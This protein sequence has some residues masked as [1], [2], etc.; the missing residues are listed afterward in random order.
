MICTD[1][2]SVNEV[3]ACSDGDAHFGFVTYYLCVFRRSLNLPV[4]QFPPLK[5]VLL[6]W[7]WFLF[8]L[9]VDLW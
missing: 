6:V 1:D 7:F 3:E 2:G 4:L 8:S 9:S 5:T